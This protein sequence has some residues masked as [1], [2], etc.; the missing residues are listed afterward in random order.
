MI[1]FEELKKKIDKIVNSPEYKEKLEKDK[2]WYARE[3]EYKISLHN[4]LEYNPKFLEKLLLREEKYQEFKYTKHH[5]ITSS[6]LFNLVFNLW[7]EN[8]KTVKSDFKK[9]EYGFL[10]GSYLYLGY[11]IQIFCGQGSFYRIYKRNKLIFQSR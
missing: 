10:A 8:G 6:R 7:V 5:V 2:R 3:N 1:D 4:L 9:D 11:K